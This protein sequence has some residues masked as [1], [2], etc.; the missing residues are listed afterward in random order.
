MGVV[1][2]CPTVSMLI[3]CMPMMPSVL[4]PRLPSTIVPAFPRPRLDADL[5]AEVQ[6]RGRPG[7]GTKLFE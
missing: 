3:M 5:R 4:P 1:L 6:T 2:S 7:V